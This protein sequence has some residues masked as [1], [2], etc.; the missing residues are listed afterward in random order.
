MALLMAG[1]LALDTAARRWRGYRA[2]WRWHF[3]AGLLVLPLLAWLALT[4]AAYLYQQPLDAWFHRTLKHV[5]PGGGAPLPAQRL[6]DAAL[7]AW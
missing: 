4:G 1:L 3:Y 6:V 7:A 2:V 5:E